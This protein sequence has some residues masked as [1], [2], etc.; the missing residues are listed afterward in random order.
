M[1]K[2]NFVTLEENKK[3]VFEKYWEKSIEDLKRYILYMCDISYIN[4]YNTVL[5]A[6]KN[7]FSLDENYWKLVKYL[8][9]NNC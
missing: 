8:E 9:E 5:Q 6:Y 2:F 3:E 1:K 4:G 7:L